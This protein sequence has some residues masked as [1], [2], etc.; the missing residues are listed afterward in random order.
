[1]D[2]VARM[3][4]YTRDVYLHFFDSYNLGI[5]PAQVAGYAVCL[6]LLWWALRPGRASGRVA[7][8][9]FAALWLWTGIVFHIMHFARIDFAATVLGALFLLQG[10]LLLLSGTILGRVRFGFD[11]GAAGWF[12]IVLV[13]AAAVLYPLAALATGT[14]WRSVAYVGVAPAT[15][16]LLTFGMLLL[17]DRRTP[18]H[19]LVLPFVLACA[20][21]ARGYAIDM[22]QD[23][24]LPLAALATL[25]LAVYRNRLSRSAG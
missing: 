9:A 10:L 15:T 22:P 23:V 1:M 14:D 19:L 25:C 7:T 3:I 6:L 2:T 21:G 17:A 5:W 12:G 24:A 16:I 8:A 4:P 11:G 20:V 13:A 18:W